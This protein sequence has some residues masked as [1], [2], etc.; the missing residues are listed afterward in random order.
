MR[1]PISEGVAQA[2]VVGLYKKVRIP[3]SHRRGRAQIRGISYV[4]SPYLKVQFAEEVTTKP[5]EATRII[6]LR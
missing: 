3:S 1:T 6:D 5:H 4:F 2:K